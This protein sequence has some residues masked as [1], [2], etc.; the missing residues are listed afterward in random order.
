MN[1]KAKGTR[2]EVELA[3]VLRE[4]G[5]PCRRSQ[6]YAGKTEDSADVVGLPYVSIECKRTERLQLD[7]A[8]AQSMRDAKESGRKP[9]VM[10]RRN[11]GHWMC[12]MLLDDWIVLYREFEA[13]HG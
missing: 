4:H 1:S 11:N 9:V 12:T 6:Q 5:Y 2:G 3:K 10:H 13:G 7:D 8:M